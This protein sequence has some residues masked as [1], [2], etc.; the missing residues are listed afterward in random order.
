MSKKYILKLNVSSSNIKQSLIDLFCEIDG[1]DILSFI[2]YKNSFVVEIFCKSRKEA[3]EFFET[4]KEDLFAER[5]SVNYNIY[6]FK[7]FENVENI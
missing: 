6:K 5:D 1:N 3:T 2:R 4:L 7:G